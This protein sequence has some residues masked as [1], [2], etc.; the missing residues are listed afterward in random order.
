VA[1][2]RIYCCVPQI[3]PLAKVKKMMREHA[4]V[5]TISA[6]ANFVLTRATVSATA[7]ARS[8]PKPW[9]SNAEQRAREQLQ[10]FLC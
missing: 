3:I 1:H 7:P 9:Y 2:E 5:K 6:D 8:P 10:G 4:D